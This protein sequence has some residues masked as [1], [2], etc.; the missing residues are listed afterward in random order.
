LNTIRNQLEFIDD[1]NILY[2]GGDDVFAVG[3]WDKLILFAEQIRN[4]FREFVGRNDIS[5]SGG[6][7]MVREKYP[8]AKAAELAGDAEK[9]AKK[10]SDNDKKKNALNMFGENI[11]W[12][13]EFDLV[14]CWKIKF[15]DMCRGYNMPRSI[16]HK[17]MEFASMK[18]RGDI[19]FAWN[20]IYYLTRFEEGKEDVIKDFCQQLQKKLF[21]LTPPCRNYELIAVAARWAELETR[22][23]RNN[24]I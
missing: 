6:I 14:K 23:N 13:K 10:Y 20:T 24:N 15:V 12:D 7:T 22:K 19:S 16:L 2:S 1:V 5:I 21:D 9:S 18:K 3:R 8:I 4:D 17:I 11:S